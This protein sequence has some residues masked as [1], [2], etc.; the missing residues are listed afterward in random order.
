MKNRMQDFETV[1]EDLSTK[2]NETNGKVDEQ[3]KKNEE[4]THKQVSVA[5]TKLLSLT[6]EFQNHIEGKQQRID[7]AVMELKAEI[8]KVKEKLDQIKITE[9]KKEELSPFIEKLALIDLLE[10]DWEAHLQQNEKQL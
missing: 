6:N 1:L 10:V 7:K 9:L 5:V 4:V 3:F 2:M 8:G